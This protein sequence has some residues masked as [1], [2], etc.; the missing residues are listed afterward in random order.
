MMTSP[1]HRSRK[2]GGSTASPPLLRRGVHEAAV[3]GTR[4]ARLLAPASARYTRQL[5][6]AL[7][8]CAS[9]RPARAAAG[10]G[11]PL[12]GAGQGVR[13]PPCRAQCRRGC[14]PPRCAT[15]QTSCTRSARQP[16]LKSSRFAKLRRSLK[17]APHAYPGAQATKALAA[18]GDL[19]SVVRG[20]RSLRPDSVAAG[21]YAG[22]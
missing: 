17:R 4:L 13:A 2:T 18:A 7:L 1:G 16:R 9:S 14:R 10:E 3:R 20:C 15:C 19:I 11:S 5:A 6:H 12:R 8:R 22:S 21:A